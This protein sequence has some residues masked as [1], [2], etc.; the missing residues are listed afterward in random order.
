MINGAGIAPGINY[1]NKNHNLSKNQIAFGYDR[2]LYDDFLGKYEQEA[3][4]EQIQL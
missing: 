3:G 2:D 4:S 1:Y